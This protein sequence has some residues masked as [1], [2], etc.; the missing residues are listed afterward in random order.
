MGISIH[1][2]G[3]LIFIMKY[4]NERDLAHFIKKYNP[5]FK[6][7]VEMLLEV[8]NGLEEVHRHGLMHGNIHAGN[9]LVEVTSHEMIS[10]KLADVGICGPIDRKSG[11]V[12]GVLPYVA[13]E[14]L[15]GNPPTTEADIY[16][17]GILMWEVATHQRPFSDRPHDAALAK[18]IVGGLRPSINNIV[19]MDYVKMM[20]ACWNAES[21]MRPRAA[22]I[23]FWLLEYVNLES[24]IDDECSIDVIDEVDP[25]A[26]YISRR[27]NFSE[28]IAC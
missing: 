28:L 25:G 26:C 27:L 10:A 6:G 8:A 21:S 9:V 11:D 16:A 4:F 18:D 2:S 24:P 13:P 15:L 14:V 1:P 22:E 20:E 23:I 17:F 3:D 7:K 19:I 12:Y 5:S